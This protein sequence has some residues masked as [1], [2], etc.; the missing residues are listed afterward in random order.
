MFYYRQMFKTMNP[1]FCSQ[2]RPMDSMQQLEQKCW[3]ISFSKIID[4]THLLLLLNLLN[5][6]K[7]ECSL[8]IYSVICIFI[9]TLIPSVRTHNRPANKHDELSLKWCFSSHYPLQIRQD[10]F[11]IQKDNKTSYFTFGGILRS[12]THFKVT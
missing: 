9:R 11:C 6:N 5:F 2:L 12:V 7:N 1:L 3:M 8:L 10:I 4:C